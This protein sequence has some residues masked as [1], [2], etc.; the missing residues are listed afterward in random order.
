M[1]MLVTHAAAVG[2]RLP[3]SLR[4]V[5]LGGDWIPVTLPGR[6][7]ELT[8]SVDVHSIG[9]ATETAIWNIWHTVGEPQPDWSS[10][11]Y[12]KPIRHNQYRV[13]DSALRDRPDLVVGELCCSGEGI[14]D[15]YFGDEV[16]TRERFV[17]HPDSGLRMYRT[18][19]LGRYRPD[20]VLEFMGRAD[21]QVKIRGQRIELGEI[22]CA[23]L[24][25]ANVS[26][27]YAVV[28]GSG[29]AAQIAAFVVPT[30]QH[31]SDYAESDVAISDS[32]ARTNFKLQGYNLRLVE[33]ERWVALPPPR[34]EAQPAG[35][36]THRAFRNQP[37]ELSNLAQLL[38]CLGQVE[39]DGLAKYG[40]PSAGSL[41]P[42]QVYVSV[43]DGAVQ[44]LRKGTYY[45][46][47]VRH[48]LVELSSEAAGYDLGADGYHVRQNRAT[49]SESAFSLF[50][51]GRMRAIE[52]LYGRA[53]RD[54]ALVEAGCMLQL[55]MS[56]AERCDLGLCPVGAV[57]FAEVQAL[58]D[59]EP[60]DELLHSMCGGLIDPTITVG[61]TREQSEA[62]R[63]S[64]VDGLRAALRG[65]LPEYMV[66]ADIQI[67]DS[68]PKTRDGKIDRKSLAKRA[69]DRQV[70]ALDFVA[71]ASDLERAIA[72]AWQAELGVREVGTSTNFFELGA[73]SLTVVRVYHRL[74]K[75]IPNEFPIVCMFQHTTIQSLGAYLRGE[76][77]TDAVV[78]FDSAR[79][80]SAERARR[81]EGNRLHRRGA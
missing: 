1:E 27:A 57:R 66:P 36:A 69:L 10:V 40:Y 52:P 30:P 58:F 16:L 46:H 54:L 6:I 17:I 23:L 53:A 18:G 42:V 33:R 32:L 37:L 63:Q 24:E 51:I 8:C 22:E 45:Y 28:A 80:R 77:Q 72:S 35:R 75:L 21:F 2:A 5:I 56:R 38:E 13:L 43:R 59:L 74:R 67:L 64:W 73:D 47:P 50:L 7:R 70:G 68:L 44:G 3:D 78:T 62:G 26:A 76:A 29:S 55:L 81:L 25:Q 20:G 79:A 65:R 61:K 48:Q 14:A 15:G 9:G 12:G 4:D 39:Q 71:P 60:E 41:Y 49:F 31:G 34:R 19:D 11:P